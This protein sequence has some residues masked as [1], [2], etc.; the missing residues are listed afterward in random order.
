MEI[1]FTFEERANVLYL[2]T[3]RYDGIYSTMALDK[4]EA[5]C[6]ICSAECLDVYIVRATSGNIYYKLNKYPI[7]DWEFIAKIEEI[8]DNLYKATL[9]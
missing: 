4:M 1:R 9:L 8:E 3:K 6:S 2:L 7:R 5:A